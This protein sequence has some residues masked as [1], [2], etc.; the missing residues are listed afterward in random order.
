M[1]QTQTVDDQIGAA[2]NQNAVSTREGVLERAFGRLF[3]GLVYAQIWE[4]PVVDMQ[5]LALTGQDHVV[6]LASGGCNMMSYLSAGPASIT[7][8]DLS[9]AH[10]ALNRLKLAAA[11]HLP[12]HAAFHDMFGHGNRAS[13]VAA[14]DRYLAPHLDEQ[15]L[16]YWTERTPSGQRKQ[17]F[18]KGL[19]RHGL[20][21]RFIGAVHLIAR[22]GRVDFRPLLEARSLEEQTAF[23]D[24]RIAPLYDSP[25]VRFLARR[26]ASL[27]GLGIPPAQYEKLAADA[28]GDIIPVLK[29]RTRKL[30]CDFP[31]EDNYFAWQ[32]ASRGYNPDGTGPM[33]PY[34]E[35]GNFDAVRANAP[36]VTVLNRSVTDMLAGQPDASKHAYVL[37]DAQD[38]M[39]D[40]QLNALWAEITR[41][42]APGARV[43]F[44]TGGVPDILPGRVVPEVLDRWSYDAA[45]SREGTRAD[46]SAIYGGFHVYR[47]KASR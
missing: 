42:A 14:F 46:R 12:D 2:V 8:V 24:A 27:F 30:F 17:I 21:G 18:R 35:P 37:L 1:S 43:I 25:G 40:R 22:L 15:T 26:R 28:G 16:K 3:R 45:A 32:A 5:A 19:Y 7:A 10:V 31:I 38:W 36:R 39:S 29:E 44:R 23:F 34:L 11:Q 41:T 47:L 13:N 4:D 33:P 6:C 9:P 20:L